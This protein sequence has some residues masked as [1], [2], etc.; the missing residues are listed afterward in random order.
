MSVWVTKVFIGA[1]L[2]KNGRWMRSLLSEKDGDGGFR[3]IA[4]DGVSLFAVRCM[5]SQQICL[6][7]AVIPSLDLLESLRLTLRLM[8]LARPPAAA[9]RRPAVIAAWRAM[10]QYCWFS[11]WDLVRSPKF[12]SSR[13][14]LPSGISSG[15][16][17]ASSSMVC[18]MSSRD[19]LWRYPHSL[20]WRVKLWYMRVS[21][22]WKFGD[23]GLSPVG[24]VEIAA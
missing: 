10:I 21:D 15:G 12:I 20:S 8:R 1:V 13:N 11:I 7:T 4:W 18:L 19:L 9:D 3:F 16:V 17:S 6:S 5:Q 22:V 2:C 23:K 14:L 24:P